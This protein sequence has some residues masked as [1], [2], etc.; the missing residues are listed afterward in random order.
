MQTLDIATRSWRLRMRVGLALA[1]CSTL[2]SG[3]LLAQQHVGQYAQADIEYGARLY[4]SH[5]VACH[6]ERGDSMP[7]ANLR[8]GQFRHA[9]T[10]REL[11]Q[12]IRD[13]IPG[14]AM[15][16][17]GYSDAERTALVAYLRNMNSADLGSTAIGDPERGRAIFAG[18]GECDSCHRVQGRG[19][20][21]APDLSAIGATRTA[22][23]LERSLTDPDAALLPINRPIRAVTADGVVIEGRR[24][25]EDTYTVQLVDARGQLRSLVKAELREYAVGDAAQM[26]SYAERLT[27][28]E[29]ADVLAYLLTLKGGL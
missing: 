24:V 23:A 5:C 10:D 1:A 15:T 4:G 11:S 22:A 26:P 21:G 13:G 25:N 9:P 12:L 19:P 28:Q 14:T 2:S 29:R 6:G 20:R 3:T 27:E 17:T 18:K 8:S 16:P 7:G